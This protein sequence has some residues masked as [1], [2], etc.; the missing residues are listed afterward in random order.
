MSTFSSY[1][2][3]STNLSRYQKLT[4]SDPTVS[5]AT[6][7]YQ[8][9]IGSVTS[10][11]ALVKNTRLFNYVM[12]AFGLSDMTYAK[13]LIQKAME[14][15]TSSSKALANTLN[16]PKIK[17]LVNTFNFAANG[18]DTTTQTA[19]SQGVVDKYVT[20]T[21]QTNEAKTNP[22][23]ELALYF[24]QNAS[25]ITDGY[26]ILADKKLLTVVQTTLGIS[27]Y[28]SSSNID[29]QAATFDKLLKYSDF[30][31]STKVQKF[32]ERFAAQYDYQ[33]PNADASSSS[34]LVTSLFNS[35]SSSG[36]GIGFDLLMSINTLKLGG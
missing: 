9:N 17:A 28:T 16:N 27:S 3:I 26:S 30:T 4:A 36:S 32:L 14:Q 24:Q 21:L 19:V 35:T 10:A 6:K 23:V 12:T 1:L 29:R 2:Q 11:A 8:A 5:Q 33:N 25:K 34:N 7:Y 18:A 22:G 13:T 31:S 15:G 20:Q